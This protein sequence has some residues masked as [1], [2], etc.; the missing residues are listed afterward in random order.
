MLVG[1]KPSLG[2]LSRWKVNLD[3]EGTE[4]KIIKEISRQNSLKINHQGQESSCLCLAYMV[5]SHN[6]KVSNRI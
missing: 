4:R 5:E 1:K 3:L 6:L 2:K